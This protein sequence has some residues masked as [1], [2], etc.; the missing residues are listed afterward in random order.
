M[1]KHW[2][3]PLAGAF[4]SDWSPAL[5]RRLATVGLTL[6][7]VIVSAAWA[8][9]NDPEPGA[10]P[11]DQSRSAVVN[12][13]FTLGSQEGIGTP[14]PASRTPAPIRATP[15]TRPNHPA[16][17]TP[18]AGPPRHTRHAV[19]P[20][21]TM[22]YEL[23]SSWADGFVPHI[24]VRNPTHESRR[25]EIRLTYPSQFQVRVVNSWNT[26]VES[27]IGALVFTGG[28]LAPGGEVTM[29]FQATKARPARADPTSCTIN[30]AAC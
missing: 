22:T 8:L 19:P 3:G 9:G 24:V 6:A 26:T 16:P 28:P 4:D 21:P 13:P 5:I 12:P 15:T 29:G 18:T 11:D 25:W 23:T 2:L 7:V 27:G 30:G 20:G 1:A 17:Y 14:P 10:R